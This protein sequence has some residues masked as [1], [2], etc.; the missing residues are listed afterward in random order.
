MFEWGMWPMRVIFLDFDGVLRSVSSMIY[1]NRLK[2]L[3]LT[4]T[5][6]HESFCPIASSN[7]QYILEERPDV[8]VVVSSDWRKNKTLK[9]LQHIFKVNNILPERMIGTTPIAKDGYRG[10]EIKAYL[11]DHPEVT[12][13]VIID[14]HDGV[15]P[16]LKRLVKVDGRNGLTFTDA[17][18]VIEMLGGKYEES[19]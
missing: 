1:N 7:L 4:D 19:K 18:K 12:K 6:T 15:K 8:Q 10:D 13:F 3:S 9:A 14:D 5:P 16:Y 2:L 11:K 17:D